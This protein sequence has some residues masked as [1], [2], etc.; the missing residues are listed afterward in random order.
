MLGHPELS[1]GAVVGRLSVGAQ[2][3]VEIARALVLDARVIVFD[4]PTSSLPGR[5]VEHLF[6]IIGKLRASGRAIIYISHFL[7][8]V[9]RIAD[10]YVVLRDGQTVGSGTLT[11][12]SDRDIVSLMVGRN[13][14]ELFPR[15]PHQQG[16]PLLELSQLSGYKIPRQVSLTLHRGEILGIAGLV[17]AGRTELLRC[18]FGLDPVQSGTIVVAGVIRRATPRQQIAAGLGLVSEDRKTE[19]LAQSL[20]VVDNMVLSHLTPYAR[21]G[22][23]RQQPRRS[24]VRQWMKQ[25]AIKANNEMQPVEELSGGNQ[26][27]VAIARVLHQ[28]ADVLLLDEPTRGID[29]GTKSQIYRLIGKAA[30]DGKAVLFVSSYVPELLAVCDRIGV[31]AR[32]S[33]Q[34]VRD[35]RDWTEEDIMSQAIGGEARG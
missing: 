4:E 10:R 3:L 6:R 9:R 23:L 28:E 31:M 35:A 19:G 13:V 27:T 14:D 26:Q 8:E 18:L 17:G 22:W 2:Q 16:A 12:V 29:V 21:W 20:S 24:S 30:A 7:E 1:L 34:E 5:D 32:G 11:G 15:V 33:L 25:L